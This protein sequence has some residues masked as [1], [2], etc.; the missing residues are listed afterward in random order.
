M[1]VWSLREIWRENSATPM[2]IPLFSPLAGLLAG[3]ERQGE[4]EVYVSETIHRKLPVDHKVSGA[5]NICSQRLTCGC[6]ATVG[7]ALRDHPLQ[8]CDQIGLLRGL[9]AANTRNSG[10]AHR[11]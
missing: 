7:I 3:P 4:M 5:K 11:Q 1:S 10:K 2:F 9:V 8:G 6:G